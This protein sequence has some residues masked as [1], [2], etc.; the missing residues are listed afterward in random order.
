M[1]R[2]KHLTA[3]VPRIFATWLLC[4]AAA[5]ALAAL[6]AHAQDPAPE[7]T[8][9]AKLL[10]LA[11]T[12]LKATQPKPGKELT[13]EDLGDI[14][15]K[16]ERVR[17]RID[18]ALSALQPRLDDAKTRLAQLGT[19]QADVKETPEVAQLRAQ[20]GRE[21]ATIDGQVKVAN[22]LA[23]QAESTL[24]HANAAQRLQ[25]SAR[26]GERVPSLLQSGFW[27]A[28]RTDS[29]A[30]LE[31]ARVFGAELGALWASV[32]AGA[33]TIFVAAVAAWLVLCLGARR[34]TARL[35]ATRIPP[36]RLRRS[37]YAVSEVVL[38]TLR[39]GLIAHGLVLT[40]TASLVDGAPDGPDSLAQW[41]DTVEMIVWFGGFIAG[42]GAALLMARK[43]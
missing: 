11:R 23:G 3:G 14:K 8:D 17:T 15:D 40:L 29:A 35:C 22:D 43:P 10:D 16:V 13:T 9:P 4:V 1:R 38:R 41:L 12:E 37:L 27:R 24:R 26:L 30:D 31:R 19:P 34:L 6:P 36:G 42:L 39:P 5:V 21:V 32:P 20:L 33:W 18:Q 28:L 25:L 2:I 7:P